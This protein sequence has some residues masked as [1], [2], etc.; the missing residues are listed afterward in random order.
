MADGTAQKCGRVGSCHI[1]L[2]DPCV[3]SVRVFLCGYFQKLVVVG[4][5]TPNAAGQAYLFKKPFNENCRAFFEDKNLRPKLYEGE[6]S[7]IDL[8]YNYSKI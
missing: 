3:Y 4:S 5:C 8:P 1:Y 2:K 6:D 7:S